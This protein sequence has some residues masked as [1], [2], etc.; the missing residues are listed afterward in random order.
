MSSRCVVWRWEPESNGT[1]FFS[2]SMQPRNSARLHTDLQCY[3][4]VHSS[5]LHCSSENL[6]ATERHLPSDHITVLPVTWHRWT[7]SAL[8]PAKQAGTRFTYPGGM[9]GWVDLGVSWSHTEMVFLSADILVIITWWRPDRESNL[10]PLDSSRHKHTI[11]VLTSGELYIWESPSN[12]GSAP[13]KVSTSDL[14]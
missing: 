6:T 5:S 10:R 11:S 3:N 7:R 9:E 4:V 14:L 13:C 1:T 2:L 8:T 12:H